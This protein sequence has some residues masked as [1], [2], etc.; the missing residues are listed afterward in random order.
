MPNSPRPV[1]GRELPSSVPR[2]HSIR[3]MGSKTEARK[4]AIAAGVPVVPGTAD[5]VSDPAEAQL[6]R[7][8]NRIPVIVKAAA[9]GG[10]KG[11]RRVDKEAD[12]EARPARCG[13][14]SRARVQE[15]RGLYREICRSAAAHRDP[16]SRRPARQYH[17]SGRAGMLGAAPPSEGDRR[18]SVAAD[19]A[20]IR[21]CAGGWARPRVKAARAAGYYNAGTV[22]F[23]VDA[24]GISISWK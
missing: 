19:V 10:G 17:P 20:S 18:V 11:M 5:G 14:R 15:Q 8:R 13:E 23:L 7:A 16:G 21:I 1:R 3:M 4:I 22:E 6:H 12:L 24:D 2:R 9:G